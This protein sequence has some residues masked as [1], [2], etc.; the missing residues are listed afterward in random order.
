[1]AAAWMSGDVIVACADLAGR[2]GASGFEIGYLRDDVPHEEA[3]WYAHANYRGTRIM[4]DE[5]RS[6]SAAALAL[7]ERILAGAECRCRRPVTMNDGTPGCRWRLVGRRW[8]PGCDAPPVRVS[9]ARGD[10]TAM[11]QALDGQPTRRERRGRR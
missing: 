5:H 11:R 7:A 8:E 1:M 2:A 10:L 6:P 3:G 4:V 9:G